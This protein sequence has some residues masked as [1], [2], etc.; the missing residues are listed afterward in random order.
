MT[1]PLLEIAALSVRYGGTPALRALDLHVNRGEV[2]CIVG[3]NGAGKSTTMNAVAGALSARQ[4]SGR[5]SL[6]GVS[7]LGKTPESIAR[8]GVSMVPEG[9]H[10]F[11]DMNVV[12]NL[13]VGTFMRKDRT[14]VQR[15][16][17]TIFELFP[18][19][20]ERRN[21][22]A[23][24]LSGGEQQMLVIGRAVLTGAQLLLIDEPSLGLAPLVTENVY[25]AL[26]QLR[27][28][29][30]L[31]LLINEQSTHRVLRYADRVYVLRGGVVRMTGGP[32][33]LQDGD[34]VREAYFGLPRSS[35][36]AE[37]ATTS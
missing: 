18:R 33:Q 5:I 20:A 6:A 36:Q 23:G 10:V 1:T 3:Q 16:M 15:E 8:M 31:T 13:K 24:H 25:R 37:E 14:Q 32:D 21:S 27:D 35:A 28:S 11:A 17:D 26:L 34:A 22:A 7:L 12:E 29:R 9:R 2:V 19:L 30:G 4:A